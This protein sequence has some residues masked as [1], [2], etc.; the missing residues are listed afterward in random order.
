M[1][2]APSITITP[3]ANPATTRTPCLVVPVFN[4]DKK[5]VRLSKSA[6]ALDKASKGVLQ[7]LAKRGDI[8][9]KAGESLLIPHLEGITAERILLVGCGTDQELSETD[10]KKVAIHTIKQLA[11]LDVKQAAIMLE[12]L[13]VKGR[14]SAWM[15]QQLSIQSGLNN[16]QYDKTLSKPKT[17]ISLKKLNLSL[18]ADKH[19]RSAADQGRAIALGMNTARDLGDLPGNI[20]TPN[21]LANQ[22][23]ALGR[24]HKKLS[25]SIVEEKKMR[26]LGMGALL[27]VSAGSDQPAKLIVMEYKGAAKSKK[28]HVLVGKGITFD[29]GGISLKPGAR[30]DEM[31]YDMCGAASVVGTMTTLTELNLPIN[32]VAIIAAA[33]NMPSGGATKPGDVVTS[34]SGQTIEVLNTDAEGRL[35]LCDALS[36]AERFKPQSIIDIA[37]LTGA[38]VVALGKHAT[39]LYSNEDDFAAEL[40]AAGNTVGDRAWHMPLWDDYQ[41]QLDS[42]FADIGNIGGP[43]GGS[44]TAACFLSRFTKN[45]RWAHMDI[46][47]TAWNSGAN[48][49]ATGRP[50]ALLTQYLITQSK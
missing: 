14:D 4:T 24:K 47:G 16:Y 42:N 44:I 6:A 1:T 38:C 21:Y 32:V 18:K 7:A 50:V 10:Y 37:T 36:Y 31:K 2:A 20:C 39:G 33:E 17:A 43:E 13:S 29:T 8:K 15:V 40:L 11:S 19:H 23:K 3:I 49:G 46:A 27:S 5:A 35:V 48:K 22:A 25:V 30:M 26:E 9:A 28:P 12:E 34:M 41:N 45:M